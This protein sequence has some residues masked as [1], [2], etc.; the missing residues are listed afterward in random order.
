MRGL[1]PRFLPPPIPYNPDLGSGSNCLLCCGDLRR[2]SSGRLCCSSK[3][4]LS[5]SGCC[6][7]L[8]GADLWAPVFMV[9]SVPG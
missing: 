3:T 2:L 5:K 8:A 9:P 4:S 1:L 7:E 6:G